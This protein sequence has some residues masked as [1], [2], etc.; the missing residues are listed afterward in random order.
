MTT[1]NTP[2][3]LAFNSEIT[4]IL[5]DREMSNQEKVGHIVSCCKFMR[6]GDMEVG[7][8]LKLV[9]LLFWAT[10]VALPRALQISWDKEN[11]VAKLSFE[12]RDYFDF[13]NE[14]F[15][16]LRDAK[17]VET[18][19]VKFGRRHICLSA[20][21]NPFWLVHIVGRVEVA[22]IEVE[23][24]TEQAETPKEEPKKEMKPKAVRNVKR[25]AKEVFTEVPLEDDD[26]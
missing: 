12:K 13:G 14:Y 1:T 2:A 5:W 25:K 15:R 4:S 18:N 24:V 23:K 9:N 19:G 6:Q 20:E 11:R 10:G 16:K 7:E 3:T 21:R 17:E 26:E 8:A 22:Q